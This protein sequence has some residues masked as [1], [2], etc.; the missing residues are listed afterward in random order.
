LAG[1]TIALTQAS[2]DITR[3]L[4]IDGDVNDDH[5]PDMTVSGATLPR[6][7]GASANV[8]SASHTTATFDGLTVTGGHPG[9]FGLGYGL[10]GGGIVAVSSSLAVRNCTISG[11]ETYSFG[12]GIYAYGG[13]LRIIGSTIANNEAY[14]ESSAAGG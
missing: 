6:F 10:G 12:G 8:F 7:Y 1:H 5:R 3:P 4:T 9:F 14:G 11:N 13:S 2:L